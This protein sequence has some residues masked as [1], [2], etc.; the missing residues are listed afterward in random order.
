MIGFK[1]V[2]GSWKIIAM[3]RPRS[4]RHT[5]GRDASRSRPRQMIRRA[6]HLSGGGRMPITARAR[7]V[8]P[9]P[10][11]PTMP[12][13]S[14]A[15]TENETSRSS[16]TFS[17]DRGIQT[18]RPSTSRTGGMDLGLHARVEDV[19]QS[20]PEEVEPQHGNDDYQPRKHHDPGSRRQ[21]IAAVG[22]DVS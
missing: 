3:L 16:K 17:P 18:E 15:D 12:R 22:D 19:A 5:A 1:A 2:I 4:R 21:E 7:T 20:I 9:L 13:D 14:P 6:D 8:L 11:S 10:D